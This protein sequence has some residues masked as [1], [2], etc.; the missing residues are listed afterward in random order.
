MDRGGRGG[1]AT[2]T[3][4]WR[5]CRREPVWRGRCIGRHHYCSKE[6]RS[7]SIGRTSIV[8]GELTNRKEVAH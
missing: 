4:W 8:T 6:S 3:T 2:G 7:L 5:G 1:G